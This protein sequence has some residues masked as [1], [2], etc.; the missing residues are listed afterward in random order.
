M[1]IDLLNFIHLYISNTICFYIFNLYFKNH[2]LINMLIYVCFRLENI[3]FFDFIQFTML[4]SI[5]CIFRNH[6]ILQY[7]LN[8]NVKND[9]F[10]LC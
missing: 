4:E 9:S 2:N 7:L 6:L 10:N 5:Y 8:F 3:R 1:L